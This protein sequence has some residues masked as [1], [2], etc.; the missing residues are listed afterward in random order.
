MITSTTT[1]GLCQRIG[2]EK[3]VE[4]IAKA[5]FDA[6]DF[7]ISSL[8][9]YNYTE[10]RFVSSDNFPSDHLKLA[11]TLKQ[12]GL[13]NGIYCNQTHTP[14]PTAI[15]YCE[16]V[17]KKS[18]ELTAEVGAKITVV[19]PKCRTNVEE[20]IEFFSRIMPFARDYGVKLAME[21]MWDWDNN[22][23]R[24]FPTNCTMPQ[25]FLEH[26]NGVNDDYLVACLDIGHAEMMGDHTNCVELIHALGN[27]IKAL[28]IHDNDKR[29]DSHECP[30]TMNI[31]FPPII[32][33]LKEEGYDGDFTL[34]CGS[35]FKHFSDD[36]LPTALKN[37]SDADRKLANLFEEL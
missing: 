31:D 3:S 30:M 1:S 7:S 25:D 4:M 37:L 15:P 6:W 22:I 17:F 23:S 27:K 34:E 14:D 20:N 10:K 8:F 26:I 12:I 24:A 21:N 19:H 18:I 35:Y 32:K 9:S 16:D 36:Q 11:R 29:L 2:F 13:D 28:H 5:G 33:A